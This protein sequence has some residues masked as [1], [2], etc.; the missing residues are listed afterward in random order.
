MSKMRVYEYAKKNKLTS[1]QVIEKLKSLNV[2]VS[3]H[4]SS[5]SGD[6]IV[7]LDKALKA[8]TEKTN[9]KPAKAKPSQQ[10][11]HSKQK[12]KKQQQGN[13]NQKME[14]THKDENKQKTDSN[15]PKQKE[16]PKRSEERRV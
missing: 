1:K 10:K 13:Q 7:K 6:T 14:S 15:K 11:Q 2:E 8:P 4:M 3:N 5:I 16:Q 12:T 9:A